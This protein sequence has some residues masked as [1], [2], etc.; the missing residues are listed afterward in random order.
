[1]QKFIQLAAPLRTGII[2]FDSADRLAEQIHG[3]FC[4]LRSIL[5][6]NMPY[7]NQSRSHIIMQLRLGRE[8]FFLSCKSQRIVGKP[9]QFAGNGFQL[10]DLRF[11]LKI[12]MVQLR[13]IRKYG[14]R[15]QNAVRSFHLVLPVTPYF[16]VREKIGLPLPGNLRHAAARIAV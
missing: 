13:D 2:I 9:F 6:E 1:M 7:G 10:P 8:H 12:F 11:Q 3:I 5:I 4:F 15:I 16:A 14:F